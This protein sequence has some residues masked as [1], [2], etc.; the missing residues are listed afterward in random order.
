MERFFDILSFAAGALSEQRSCEFAGG[1]KNQRMS[2]NRENER[3]FRE[4]IFGL[5]LRLFPPHNHPLSYSLYVCLHSP[6]NKKGYQIRIPFPFNSPFILFYN[7]SITILNRFSQPSCSLHAFP[8]LQIMHPQSSYRIQHS[9]HRHSDICE[10]C[11]PHIR[12]SNRS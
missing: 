3:V 4:H 10:N 2:K 1:G 6:I 12:I 8:L 7:Q 9:N 5:S 11:H